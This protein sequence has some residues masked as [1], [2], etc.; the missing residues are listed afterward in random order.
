MYRLRRLR[1]WSAGAHHHHLAR[2]I[3]GLL[4]RRSLQQGTTEAVNLLIKKI[5]RVAQG[6]RNFDNYRLRP[7][8]HSPGTIKLQH[9]Y[10]V[11]H[12]AWLLNMLTFLN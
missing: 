12:H 10:D 8:L 6:F 3:A 9:H 2:Q 5:L 4:K 11:D 1:N 7:L